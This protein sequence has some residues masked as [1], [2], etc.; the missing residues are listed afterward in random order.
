MCEIVKKEQNVFEQIEGSL[1]GER[2]LQMIKLSIT[3]SSILNSSSMEFSGVYGG[4][5]NVHL[6]IDT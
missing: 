2:Y 1:N 4:C 6:L 5:S 3:C